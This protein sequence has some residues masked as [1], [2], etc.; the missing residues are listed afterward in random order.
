MRAKF[1]PAWLC[2]RDTI[3]RPQLKLKR[4]QNLSYTASRQGSLNLALH[5]GGLTIG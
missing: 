3:K 4:D 2:V 5:K 1:T